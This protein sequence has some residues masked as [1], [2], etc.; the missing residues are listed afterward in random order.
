MKSKSNALLFAFSITLAALAAAPHDAVASDWP[1]W[2]GA[3]R[4]DHS[5]ET[6]LLKS[7]PAGGPKQLWVYKEAGSG[8]SGPS[9]VADKYYTM[10]TRD[11]QE[12]LIALDAKT[13]K[14]LWTTKLGLIL[15]NGYG[16]GPRGTPTVDGDRIYTMSGRGDLSC[17]K[18]ADGSIV[19]TQSMEKLGGKRPGWGYTESVLVDGPQVVCTPGGSKGAIAALDKTTGKTLWQTMDF[20]DG[21]QYASLVPINNNGVHQYIQQTMQSVAGV[22]AKDGKLVWRSEWQGKTAVIPTPI[23]DDGMVYVSAGYGVGCKLIKLGAG[24][25]ASD[26]YQNT[27]MINHHG[28]VILLDGY[29]YG[30]SD[31]GGWTCQNFK[32]GA[33][34][35]TSKALGKGAVGYADGMLYC[36]E[37]KSG[38]VALVEASPLAWKEH[39]RLTLDPQSTIR[40]SQGR[41][42]THPVI[43][44]G[45]LY[46]RDQDLIYCYNVKG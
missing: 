24:G 5:T 9:I 30:F 1:Q 23:Y 8:Y 13:G 38:T 22:S 2:R 37:E 6:G 16:D 10:G 44:N 35:W 29:L 4:T 43:V 7:W 18:N 40:S 15:K 26:V 34:V 12:I 39:G 19:W 33:A 46:L 11:D 27:V 45:R 32:S 3:D 41:I 17:V 25:E 21:A 42:W 14:E 20:T 28:G 36:L 31:K